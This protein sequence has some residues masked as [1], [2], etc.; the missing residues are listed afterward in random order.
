L[1]AAAA[2]LL[3][4]GCSSSGGA[5]TDEQA[6]REA[7][8]A[9]LNTLEL[10]IERGDVSLASQGISDQ[11]VLGGNAGLRYSDTAWSGSGVPAFRAFF[12]SSFLTRVNVQQ[13]FTLVTLDVSGELAQALAGSSYNATR[14]DR[15]PPEA[16]TAASQDLLVFRRE[17]GAWRLVSWDVAPAHDEGQAATV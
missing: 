6:V 10:G 14:I 17:G 12:N 11:F 13:D 15:V 7:V 2:A 4:C 3:L 16:V 1:L 9:V 8:L 5:A